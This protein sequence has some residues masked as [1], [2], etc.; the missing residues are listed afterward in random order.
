MKS[1][2]SK[3]KEKGPNYIKLTPIYTLSIL[4]YWNLD[5][6]LIW[7]RNEVSWNFKFQ[8]QPKCISQG[9]A[10]LTKWAELCALHSVSC[11]LGSIRG[12]LSSLCELSASVLVPNCARLVLPRTVSC[13]LHSFPGRVKMCCMC[14]WIALSSLCELS[15]GA[16]KEGSLV[17]N[18]EEACAGAFPWFSCDALL[19]CFLMV[20]SSNLEECIWPF[21]AYF[22]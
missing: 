14:P 20:V 22:P 9:N 4:G 15:F 8:F 17:R 21:F 16:S 2:G 1:R 19:P 6:L 11:W 5:G 13:A 3:V 12:E 7:W 18:L 10:Q